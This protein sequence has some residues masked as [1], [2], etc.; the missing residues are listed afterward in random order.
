MIINFVI[1]GEPVGKGR[2]KFTTRGR[3]PVAYTPEKT[4]VY[5]NHVR[6]CYEDYNG[7]ML[8][9]A[10]RVEITGYFPIPKSASKKQKALMLSNQ[11]R[12]TKKID[13]DNMAKIV[14]DALNG[15]AYE[16]DKQVC[17]LYVK[18]MYSDVPRVEVILTE[19]E[20]S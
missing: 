13:A 8:S 5:E 11:I 6:N 2:P 4:R 15:V 20:S 16:D 18:K 17:E 7:V 3:Y 19:L 14:M 9:G 10:L 12:H 1:D